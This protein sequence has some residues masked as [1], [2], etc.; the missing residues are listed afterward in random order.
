MV[1]SV[2][3][4]LSREVREHVGTDHLG[5][6]YYYVAQ[7][8]NWRGESEERLPVAARPGRVASAV[9]WN[10]ASDVLSRVRGLGGYL[11]LRS[12]DPVLQELPEG[13]GTAG[14]ALSQCLALVFRRRLCAEFTFPVGAAAGCSP[15]LSPPSLS[16]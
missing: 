4:A 15:Y 13:L 14:K 16:T 3:S 1:R 12:L 11:G 2:W 6:K 7:Y 8:K 5:N 10:R 9:L